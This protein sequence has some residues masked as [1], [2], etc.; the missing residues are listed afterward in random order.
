MPA[1]RKAQGVPALVIDDLEVDLKLARVVLTQGGFD[2]RT[3]P[4]V[5]AALAVLE[6]F[7]P[8]I[9]VLD[10]GMPK[11]D[12]LGLARQ[13]KAAAETQDIVIVAVSAYAVEAEARAAG[14]AGFIAKPIDVGT[15]ADRVRRYLPARR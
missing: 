10:V 12:G 2:V 4:S 6:T 14:C 9:I 3:A 5:D 15:F 8:Q 1:S 11:A 13:L 7:R